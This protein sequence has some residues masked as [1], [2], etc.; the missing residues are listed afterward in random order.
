MPA[1]SSFRAAV[2]SQAAELPRLAGRIEAQ[3][4]RRQWDIP[5]PRVV[6]VG[7]GASHGALGTF[8]RRLEEHGIPVAIRTGADGP[9]PIDPE[10]W[11]V[12]VS[13]SGRSAEVVA[14]LEG[15][16]AA[17]RIVVVNRTDSPLAAMAA[18]VLDLGG[19]ADSRV[20]TIGFTGTVLALVALAD[21]M[22]GRPLPGHDDPV[23][24][25][26]F[27][28]RCRSWAGQVEPV[29]RAA[30]AVDVVGSAHSGGIVEAGALLLREGARLPTG[31]FHT[32]SYLHGY[33]DCAGPQTAHVVIDSGHEDL[34][35]RQLRSVGAAVIRIGGAA[36]SDAHHL[37]LPAQGL[38]GGTIAVSVALQHLVLAHAA[39]TGEQPEQSVFERVDT[40]LTR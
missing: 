15:V 8:A 2:E 33:M 39:A 22:A 29:L 26:S 28:G 30:R 23:G 5:V 19:L 31:G 27:A 17:Q 32:R 7:I 3:L 25:E 9:G 13:Q 24:L 34:L 12:G 1:W 4:S 6:G 37:P 14:A 21:R 35:I 16:P 10:A 11:Y 20:S 18:C 36:G 38:P 40:K